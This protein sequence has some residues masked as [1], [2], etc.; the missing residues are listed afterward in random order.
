LQG[1][2]IRCWLDEKQLLPGDDMHEQIDRGIRLW[3]KVLL[4]CSQHSLKGSWWVDGEIDK[5]FQKEQQLM[6]TRG[7]KVLALIPLNLDG[8]LF[9]GWESGK[10]THVRSRVAPDFRGSDTDHK[11]FEEQVENVIRA[12]RADEGGREPSPPTKL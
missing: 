12:L 8:Y 6:K 10:A 9:N 5:A 4:C 1:R 11:I 3:D 2:G 7:K